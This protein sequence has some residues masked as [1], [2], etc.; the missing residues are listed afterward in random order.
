MIVTE[1]ISGLGNQMFQYAAGLALAKRNNTELYIDNSWFNLDIEKQTPRNYGM[2]PFR[3]DA[4]IADEAL[5]RKF[6]KAENTGLFSRISN[7]LDSMQPYYLR[8]V[9][10]EPH[11]QYDP[12]FQKANNNTYLSGYWQSEKYF[13]DI[14]HDVRAS[15][16]LKNELSELNVKLKNEISNC[17]AI[18]LHVRRTDMVNNPEV[19]KTHGAC[20]LDYYLAAVNQ[21]SIGLE[22]PKFFI[23]SDDP[24]W[25]KENLHINFPVTYIDH[26]HGDDAYLDMH[27][28]SQCKH[29]IIANS[30]F[31]WWGAWLNS[32]TDKRVIAP[33]RWFATN[34]KDTKDIIPESWNR[35]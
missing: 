11:F 7:K 32:N 30:S 28:M 29:H 23:F 33:K 26:N 27:L 17:M 25:C 8:K 31:S 9:Y 5:I 34:D 20:T 19:I 15:F 10:V 14:E 35:I 16:R 1:L 2:T 6:I 22:A 18:S 21:I 24:T 12:N 13:K 3:I 4:Q